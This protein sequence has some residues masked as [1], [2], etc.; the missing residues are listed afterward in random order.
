MRKYESLIASG[1]LKMDGDWIVGMAAD[2]VEVVIGDLDGVDRVEV[3]LEDH[4]T[5]DTW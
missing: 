3:Y 1:L 5:P 2:G 4:P